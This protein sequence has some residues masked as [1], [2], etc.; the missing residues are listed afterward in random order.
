M[1]EIWDAMASVSGEEPVTDHV[2]QRD[3]CSIS[4]FNVY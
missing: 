1:N 2:T 3:V 4:S